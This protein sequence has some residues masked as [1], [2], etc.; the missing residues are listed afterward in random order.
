MNIELLSES[1]EDYLEAIY[2]ISEASGEARAKE[3]ATR[4]QVSQAS[5]TEALHML[6]KKKLVN[7]APYNNITLTPLGKEYAQAIVKRHLT[8]KDFFISILNVEESLAEDCSCRI[9]HVIPDSILE[10]FVLFIEQSKRNN[11]TL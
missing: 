8:L 2:H 1:Q 9:E 3:V 6:K 10:K 7:H 5:V 11:Q 4:L